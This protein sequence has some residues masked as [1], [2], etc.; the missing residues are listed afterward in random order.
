MERSENDSARSIKNLSGRPFAKQASLFTIC[1]VRAENPDP[2]FGKTPGI[3]FLKE[4]LTYNLS[5]FLGICFFFSV[6]LGGIRETLSQ[7][8]GIQSY[9][10]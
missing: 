6:E 4:F 2:D 5:R 1:L 9:T 10:T 3:I 8:P 7:E